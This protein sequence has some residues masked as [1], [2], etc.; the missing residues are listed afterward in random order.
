MPSARPPG[1]RLQAALSGG[2]DRRNL[3]LIV[4]GSML[5]LLIIPPAHD[6]PIIDDWVYA[7]SVHHQL[8][9]GIFQMPP[10][11]E[12]T[13]VGLTL[14]G[15]L[16][17]R[18][19][20][21]SY[22]T[23]TL[24]TLVLAL[25]GLL[26]FYATARAVD[27]PTGGALLGTVLL[28]VQPLFLHLSFSFMTDV[29][30][31]T[32]LL[33]ACYSYLRG[34]LGGAAGWWWLGGLAIG[35]AFLIRQFALLVPCAFLLYL[36]LD[37]LLTRRP[38]WAQMVYLALGPAMILLG[39]WLWSPGIRPTP[40]VGAFV[41][42]GTWLGVC[43]SRALA[44][45]PLL[46]LAAP[47]LGG[48]RRPH[49]GWVGFWSAILVGGWATVTAVRAPSVSHAAARFHVPG[50]PL[51]FDLASQLNPFLGFGNILRTGGIDFFDY[52]QEPIWTPD[53][54]GLFFLGASALGVLLLAQMSAMFSVAWRKRRQGD[55]LPPRASLYLTGLALGLGALALPATLYD[56]YLL[57]CIPFVIL[58][59]VA[60]AGS[61]GKGLRRALA[62]AMRPLVSN[63]SIAVSG[64]ESSSLQE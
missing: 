34:L 56:R 32:L 64:S 52:R 35:M 20:G 22:T 17:A 11:S 60:Q 38:R 4:L 55:W 14:W 44:S 12:V 43:L 62:A 23:L 49:W 10:E 21:F 53:A 27:V 25:A 45:L 42:H 13:L 18:L 31:L 50:G 63:L 46:G 33:A 8:A 9:T 40:L 15:T 51:G 2:S 6:Y 16:W 36:A 5:M 61:W 3:G 57:G 24:S 47:A 1:T 26:T 7:R 29:P 58:F 30:C 37:G 39:W 54:W 28:A 48:I 19:L 59:G 41:G